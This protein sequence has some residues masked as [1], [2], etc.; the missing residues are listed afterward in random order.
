MG[1]QVRPDQSFAN[2][3]RRRLPCAGEKWHLD[4]VCLMIAGHW[5]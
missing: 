5:L 4:E 3:I 1:A 2:Q